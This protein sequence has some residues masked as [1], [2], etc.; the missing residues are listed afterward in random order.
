MDIIVD[1]VGDYNNY[2]SFYDV[3]AS[4]GRFVRI[5][6]TSCEEKYVPV[7]SGEKEKDK[8]FS[9]LN[10]YKGSRIN[11]KAID[12][13]I[14]HCF[15]EDQELFTEDLAYLHHLL[16]IGKIDPKVFSQVGFNELEE[17]WMKVMLGGVDGVV[18]VSPWKN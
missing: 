17:E 15:N 6:T 11:K 5:N 13:E 12:Y 8:I 7:L 10:D 1:T 18:V 16:E 4:G 3:M 14:F 2:T 9:V